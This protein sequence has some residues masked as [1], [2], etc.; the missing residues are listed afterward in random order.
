MC[1][2]GRDRWRL[3]RVKHGHS[4]K[5]LYLGLITVAVLWLINL[6]VGNTHRYRLRF[7]QLRTGPNIY[8]ICRGVIVRKPVQ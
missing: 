2:Y 3:C 4:T 8:G 1:A 5:T 6:N 7:S